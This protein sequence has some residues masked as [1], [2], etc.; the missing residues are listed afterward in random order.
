[1]KRFDGKTAI[2][3]GGGTGIGLATA[4]RLIEDGAFVYIA[5]RRKDVLDKAVAEL[6]PN[7]RAVRLD[8][9][10]VRDVEAA[11]ETV[12]AEKGALDI[13]V[14]NAGGGSLA[15][16]GEITEAQ[17]ETTFG[18]NVKGVIFTVQAALPLM[19][20]GGAIILTGSTTAVKGEPAFSIYSASK[21][22]VR[23]LAR[24]WSQDLRGT[25]VRV[26]VVT[27]GPTRTDTV[28]DVLGDEAM[29]ALAAAVP[30]GRI[31]EP[32][33]TASVIAFL[34]SGE[35]SFMTGSEVYVDGGYAQV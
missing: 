29:D 22:A 30:L 5:G 4:R 25:G 1:M 12:K 32:E 9:S 8:V 21:A 19:K 14:A 3:T 35:S 20:A 13:V 18:A 27:P 34:A 16:L 15:P 7:A 28:F 17:Y 24:S 10:D 6:G 11:F 33:E 2:V 26:N 23:N 31:A